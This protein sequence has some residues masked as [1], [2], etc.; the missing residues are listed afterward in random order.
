MTCAKALGC[1]V[2]VGAF[3]LD[4][5]TAFASLAPGDHG[6]TYGGN[7]FVCAAVSKVLDIFEQDK[8]VEHARQVGAY[9]EEKLDALAEKYDF[10]AER[11]DGDCCRAWKSRVDRR[12]ILC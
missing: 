4:E 9:L 3:V 6:T 7:P 2:P 8:I 11:R 12:T 10:I 5:K 1:G